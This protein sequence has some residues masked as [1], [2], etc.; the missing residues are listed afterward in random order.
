MAQMV[1]MGSSAQIALNWE[2]QLFYPTLQNKSEELLRISFGMA[3]W[4]LVK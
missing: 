1:L 2:L 4:G 3:V